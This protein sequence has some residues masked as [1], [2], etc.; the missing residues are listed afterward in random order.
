M[1]DRTLR[2]LRGVKPVLVVLYRR[3]GLGVAAECGVPNVRG[4]GMREGPWVC[5]GF[6]VR[7]LFHA[8]RNASP[9][10][11]PMFAGD[12]MLGVRPNLE[13]S[14][15]MRPACAGILCREAVYTTQEP[16]TKCMRNIHP[17]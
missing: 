11:L 17:P 12:A 13:K 10:T 5:V 1:D 14:N 9:R 2:A 16:R 4:E 6:G 15:D 7:E 3:P 8:R